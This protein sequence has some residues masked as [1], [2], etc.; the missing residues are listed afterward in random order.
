MTVFARPM[1]AVVF[2][3]FILCAETCLHAESILRPAQWVDLPIHDWLAGAFLLYG[4]VKARRDWTVGRPYLASA[5]AF[6]A[7][8]LAAA[9]VGHWEEWALGSPSG[10]WISNGAFVVIIG[11]LLAISACGTAASLRA[12]A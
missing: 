7:S 2:A 8:L 4:A 1:V 5:W 3:A 6:M 12:R 11:V 9:F 10:E